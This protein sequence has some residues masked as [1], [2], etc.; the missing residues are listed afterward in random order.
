MTVDH[1]LTTFGP[2]LALGD[3][4]GSHHVHA[5]GCEDCRH[6][7]PGKRYGGES[8]GWSANFATQLEVVSEIY[9]EIIDEGIDQGY[10]DTY[11]DGVAHYRGEVWFAPC[12]K[13]LPES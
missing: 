7:G 12:T 11:E 6:Y 3:S 9:G 8:S 2:N 13:D 4:K 5:A 10:H 1:S